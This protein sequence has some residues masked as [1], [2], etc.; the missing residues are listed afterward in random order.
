M[1][2]FRLVP[3]GGKLPNDCPHSQV[4]RSCWDDGA[5]SAA[6]SHVVYTHKQEEPVVLA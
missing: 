1:S 5:M 2:T 3:D 6:L 4:F